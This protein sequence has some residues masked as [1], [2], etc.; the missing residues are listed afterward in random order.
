MDF[1]QT[2]FSPALVNSSHFPQIFSLCVQKF[3]FLSSSF[4]FHQIT[5]LTRENC[6][7]QKMALHPIIS[8]NSFISTS[9]PDPTAPQLETSCLYR[10]V[11]PPPMATATFSVSAPKLSNSLPI[12]IR[13]STS[14][15]SFKTSLKTFLFKQFI[16]N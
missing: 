10:A 5:L 11:T 12:E 1:F 3:H 4:Q 8:V 13:L 2:S 15:N 9:Q 6:C 7:K 14:L 16:G